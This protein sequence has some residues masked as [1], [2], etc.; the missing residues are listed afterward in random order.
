M[1][2]IRDGKEYELTFS[3]MIQAHE[4]YELDC[5]V[6]D[7][8]NQYEQGDYDVELSEEDI[9]TVASFALH[10]LSKNDGYFESYWM[11]VQYTLDNYI[12]NMSVDEEEDD[13]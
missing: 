10:D 9:G 4:E 11:T 5:M 13:E 6:E 8:R 1:K 3:E 7:V 2:I 12:N